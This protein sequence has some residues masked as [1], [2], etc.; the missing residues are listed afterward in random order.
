MLILTNFKK[1][2]KTLNL[3][4]ALVLFNRYFP[5]Q[6]FERKQMIIELKKRLCVACL[7]DIKAYSFYELPCKCRI[8]SLNHLNS[9]LSFFQDFKRGFFCN[10]KTFYDR[11][12]MMELIL[13]KGLNNDINTRIK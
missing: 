8:C 9:Y 11:H 13:I 3:D 2:K 7:N 1:E 6:K 4:E 5:N 12:M 10:C